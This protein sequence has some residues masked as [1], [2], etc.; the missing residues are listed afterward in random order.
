MPFQPGRFAN[1]TPTSLAFAAV[2]MAACPSLAMQQEEDEAPLLSGPTVEANA[3]QATLVRRDFSGEFQRLEHHP[4]EAALDL[5]REKF[6]IEEAPSQAIE[7]ILA[8][9]RTALDDLVIDRLDVLIKLSNGG[10]DS[11]R[12]EAIAVLRRAMAPIA[13]KGQL[14]DRIRRHLPTDAATEH[15]R[16]E[17]EYLEAAIED[18]V[19]L[20]QAEQAGMGERGL[21]LRARAIEMLVGLG[22]EVKGAYERTIVQQGQRVEELIAMLTLSPE[23]EGKVRQIIQQYGEK[24][25]L[26]KEARDDDKSRLAV[27]LE[28]AAELTPEQRRTLL[29]HV[30]GER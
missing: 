26:N 19:A 10:N 4:A 1:R 20:L 14:G 5:V 28:V 12:A 23:Q 18:R 22:A 3:E 29:E 13:R 16:L 30:R 15:Q 6:T 24:T 25:L 21:R 9:R 7:A 27:F 17:R 11:D 2:L 8:E